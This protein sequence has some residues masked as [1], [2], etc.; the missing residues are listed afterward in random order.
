LRIGRATGVNDATPFAGPALPA[1]KTGVFGQAREQELRDSRT[2]SGDGLVN[3]LA[4]WEAW[5]TIAEQTDF[6]LQLLNR[7]TALKRPFILPHKT[8]QLG[9]I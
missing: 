1:K 4:V 7:R 3:S 8:I 5:V 6:L 2:I 9:N